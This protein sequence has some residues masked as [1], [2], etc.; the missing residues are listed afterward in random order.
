MVQ[1]WYGASLSIRFYHVFY[2]MA[3]HSDIEDVESYILSSTY[4]SH[5]LEHLAETVRATPKEI[6]DSVDI[7][8]PHVS[9]ALSELREHDVVE[10]RVPE[11]RTVGRYYGLTDRGKEVWPE[12]KREIQRVD[13]TL[14]EPST[15]T[16]R[17]LVELARGEFDDRLRF[18][19]VYDEG[20]VSILYADP[21]VLSNYTDEQFEEALRTL[22]FDHSLDEINI[23]SDECW[24][25]VLHFTEFSVFRVR[26]SDGSRVSV[27]FDRGENVSVP[28][29]AESVVSIFES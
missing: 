10:L 21:E 28:E 2:E 17:S 12:I 27:S 16:E 24:S 13:W 8:R 6:A 14:A 18:V 26:I 3:D 25:E 7:R 1:D 4:R 19:G 5:V 9:R 22:V 29:F 23:Q 20:T 15:P 11:G